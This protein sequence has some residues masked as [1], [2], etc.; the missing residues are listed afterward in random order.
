MSTG[1]F[2]YLEYALT[3]LEISGAQAVPLLLQ[4]PLAVK[5]IGGGDLE[6]LACRQWLLVYQSLS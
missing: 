3:L 5:Q 2:L 4:S 6:I 1:G